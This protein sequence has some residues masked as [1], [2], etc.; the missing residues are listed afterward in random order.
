MN[1]I[2]DSGINDVKIIY[3]ASP[4]AMCTGYKA[5]S[6]VMK[7]GD[8]KKLHDLAKTNSEQFNIVMSQLE[9]RF[10]N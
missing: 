2:L 8:F 3:D 9:A 10:K 4:I 6:L 1:I 5:K 7:K